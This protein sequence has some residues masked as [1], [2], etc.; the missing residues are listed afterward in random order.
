V[1]K[2]TATIRSYVLDY[3]ERMSKGG[4]SDRRVVTISPQTGSRQGNFLN[5]GGRRFMSRRP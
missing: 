5:A 2:K 3:I 4:F 1:T